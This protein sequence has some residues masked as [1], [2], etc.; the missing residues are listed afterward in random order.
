MHVHGLG[1]MGT[2]ALLNAYGELARDGGA[3]VAALDC[4]AVEPTEH[5]LIDALATTL[6]S[7]ASLEG[8]LDMLAAVDTVVLV[9]DT[10]ERFRLMDSAT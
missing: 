1:G 3:T 5:G 7:V 8:V 4:R 9:L 6:G 2:T 10:Y